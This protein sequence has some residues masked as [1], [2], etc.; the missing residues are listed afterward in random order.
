[1]RICWWHDIPWRR[2]HL[3]HQKDIQINYDYNRRYTMRDIGK[4]ESRIGKLEYATSLGLLERET[5]SFQVLDEN[6][7]DRFKAG[8]IVDNFYGMNIG[9]TLALDYNCAVDPGAGH[10]RPLSK[11]HMATLVEENTTDVQ[12]TTNEYQKTG[13]IITLPIYS[14]LYDYTTI[15]Q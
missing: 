11:Q 9:N 10:L 5:N 3:N 14:Y 2:T 12:R 8:F 15:C 4:L 13:D 6:G 7:L 1:M